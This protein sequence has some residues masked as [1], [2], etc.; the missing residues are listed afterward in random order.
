MAEF[1]WN[2][3][4]ASP[5][6][7]SSTPGAR[8]TR[9]EIALSRLPE[10]FKGRP[11]IEALIRAVVASFDE[12][13]VEARRLLVERTLDT[14]VGAQLDV[15]GRIVGQPRNGLSDDDFRRFCRARVR[16]NRSK[17]TVSDILR[18]TRLVVNDPDARFTL[19]LTGIAAYI[20]RI[21]DIV[22]PDDLAAIVFSFLKAVTS[23]GV[24]PMLGY[25]TG[26]PAT[27]GRWGRTR[28]GHSRWSRLIG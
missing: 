26:D 23:G 21:E 17:G 20:L 4:A 3:P 13:D 15:I 18:V 14:A 5:A 28:W 2:L 8:P 10:Q 24:R 22:V 11:N 19:Q 12:F 1:V 25:T 7:T 9:I 6:V 16:A 27:R